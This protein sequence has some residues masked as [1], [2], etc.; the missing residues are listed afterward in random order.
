MADFPNH[1]RR[2][3]AWLDRLSRDPEVSP[4]AFRVAYVIGSFMNRETGLAWPSV[5]TIAAASCLSLSAAKRALAALVDGGHLLVETDRGRGRSN[6]YRIPEPENS[7][8]ADCF[9]GLENGSSVVGKRSIHDRKTV[10]QWTPNT[11]K[12]TGCP[13]G[14]PDEHRNRHDA[15]APSGA[16]LDN[17]STLPADVR[18]DVEDHERRLAEGVRS[19]RLTPSEAAARRA[20]RA[21]HLATLMETCPHG[22]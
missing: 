11:K 14:I 5:P 6:R 19:G 13:S 8:R 1:L 16:A 4:A 10:H 22:R 3:A 17:L 20:E 21:R 9:N 12:N 15:R 7:P 2:R 18:A